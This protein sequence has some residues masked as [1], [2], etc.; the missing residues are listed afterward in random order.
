ME[1]FDSS[2]FKERVGVLSLI[3]RLNAKIFMKWLIKAK[4][5]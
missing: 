5:Y 1:R 4:F 2:L 3:R